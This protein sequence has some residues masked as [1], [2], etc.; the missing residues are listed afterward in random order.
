[1]A[2]VERAADRPVSSHP[3]HEVAPVVVV[4][5]GAGPRRPDLDDRRDAYTEALEHAVKPARR[6]LEE[7]GDALDA[8]QAAVAF[9]EDE[10]DFFNAGRGSV[11][12]ADGT[13]EM[14]AAVM[15]GPDQAAGAVAGVRRTRQPILAA[16]AILEEGIHVLLAGEAADAHAA[17]A[18]LEQREPS[19]FVTERQQRRTQ[20]F[21]SEFSGN[22]V[23][24][25]CRDRRGRLAAATSTGGRRGQA[26]GRVGDSPVFGA[27]TWADQH[28][29]ISCT[30]HGEAFIRIGVARYIATLVSLGTS[31]AEATERALA[32]VARLGGEG[33]L[34]AVGH[35][36][37]GVLPF[38]T[39]AMPRAQ[40]VEGEALTTWV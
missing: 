36:G 2:A 25:V 12:C 35:T 34:V 28:V 18:G 37:S 4:H 10:V 38:N 17:A 39:G 30:G 16:R 26:P 40:W 15:R 27:G 5:A 3:H 11:L 6:I 33:G 7:G 19:Y 32:E 31:L 22:T 14:S 8:A 20:R 1:M 29:A 21:G 13:V 9:M 24:A 23:G